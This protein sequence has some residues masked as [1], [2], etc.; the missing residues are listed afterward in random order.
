M[1]SNR[2]RQRKYRE[3][4]GRE[5]R[6]N[7][8]VNADTY[9]QLSRLATYYGGTRREFLEVVIQDAEYRTLELMDSYD[10]TERYFNK[11]PPKSYDSQGF[12]HVEN[13][14]YRF[15]KAPT[16]IPIYVGRQAL[17]PT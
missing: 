10:E 11:I 8:V 3:K 2:E 16:H 13:P 1:T 6:I 17:L 12:P 7:S 9:Q 15:V 5:R 14:D 4:I